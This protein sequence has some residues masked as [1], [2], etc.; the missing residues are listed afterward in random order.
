MRAMSI[1]SSM[2]SHNTSLIFNLFWGQILQ[3]TADKFKSISYFILFYSKSRPEDQIQSCFSLLVKFNLV[4][5]HLCPAPQNEPNVAMYIL[6]KV[7]LKSVNIPSFFRGKNLTVLMK[8]SRHVD[9][10]TESSF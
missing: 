9:L 5:L 3:L 8:T 6:K 1:I 2:V 4:I 10:E 7:I